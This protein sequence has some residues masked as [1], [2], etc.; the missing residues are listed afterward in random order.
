MK[1]SI[2]WLFTEN[3]RKVVEEKTATMMFSAKEAGYKAIYP[4]GQQFIGFKEAE[5]EL[6]P[7][8]QQFRIKYLGRHKP[9]KL[10]EK[11]KGYWQ[12]IDNQLMTLFTI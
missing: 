11:G 4:I 12:L 6:D 5:I 10:L 1:S 8:S 3:E 7:A 2:G 9:N